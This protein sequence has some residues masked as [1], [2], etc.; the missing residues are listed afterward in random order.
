MVL[1]IFYSILTSVSKSHFQRHT[2][3]VGPTPWVGTQDPGV[4][5]WGRTLGWDPG[6]GALGQTLG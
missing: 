3:K 4:A 2:R 6:M 1:I 5:P